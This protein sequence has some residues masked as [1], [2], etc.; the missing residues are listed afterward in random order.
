MAH[1][2]RCHLQMAKIL[3]LIAVPKLGAPRCGAQAGSVD[4]E[5]AGL[6]PKVCATWSKTGAQLTEQRG[7]RNPRFHNKVLNVFGA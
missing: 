5:M 4:P 2:L 7:T 3:D 6:A 1:F